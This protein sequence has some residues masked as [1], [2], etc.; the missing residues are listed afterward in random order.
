MNGSR[1]R[2]LRLRGGPLGALLDD[3]GIAAVEFAILAPIFGLIFAGVADFGNV[4]FTQFRLSAAVSAGANYAMVNQANVS[5]TG[6]AALA[7]NIA[8]VVESNAGSN[9]ADDGI[10][11]NNGPSKT[12][13]GGTGSTGGTA[14]NADSCYCPTLAPSF[15]WGSSATCASPC[16]GGGI[17]GKFVTITAS[18]S[19]TP[20]FS[21]Y[22]IVS[23]GTI[24]VTTAVQTS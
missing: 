4:L 24:T 14:S 5:S 9:W 21:S 17:A 11:V 12:I 7:S 22:G 18:H 8:Q 10:V 2:L 23:N 13:T 20:L 1:K 3:R 6:G 15:T 16:S 19:Y